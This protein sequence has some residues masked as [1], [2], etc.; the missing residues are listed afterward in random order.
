MNC[1]KCGHELQKRTCPA[2]GWKRRGS[3][4]LLVA[5]LA[6][7]ALL[8]AAVCG[9]V[10]WWLSRDG[11]GAGDNGDFPTDPQPVS[12]TTVSNTVMVTVPEGYTVEKI[13]VLLEE[14]GVCTAADFRQAVQEGD[15][16]DYAF[17]AD[18]PAEGKAYRLEGYLFPDTY[19]FYKNSSGDAAVRRFLA[20]FQRK[21]ET[22]R[23]ALS[24]SGLTMD[25][26]VTLASIIQWE[27]K[28]P[29]DMTRVSRVLHNR[30]NSPNYPRLQCDVTTRYL[31][32][33]DAAGV[34]VEKELYDTYIRYNLPVGAISNPGLSAL[35][36][37]VSPSNEE[38]CA[39]CYF[40]VTDEANNTVYYSKTYAE[41]LAVWDRIQNG[42]V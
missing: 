27:A 41:H 35:S 37:A 15:F 18:I 4:V 32:E 23:E 5:L 28:T 9:G 36:A 3:V 39:D 8:F 1:P 34:P 11:G 33:L 31:R 13:A 7:A 22:V 30:L 6:A 20:N 42:E 24:A 38:L 29:T 40:F 21:L 16:S 25:E 10:W 2:C 14:S 19:E 26:A 17:V 12:T